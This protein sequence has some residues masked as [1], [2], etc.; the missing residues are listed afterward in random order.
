MGNRKFKNNL[1][2][3]M[4]IYNSLV[5]SII[6]YA[7]EIWGWKEAEK[8]EKLQTKYIKWILGLDYNTPTHIV[9]RD[10]DR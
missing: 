8:L 1:E 5:K 7:A 2:R 9:G 6:L 3:R 4:R 10:E